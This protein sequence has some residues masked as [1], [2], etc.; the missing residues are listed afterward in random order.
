MPLVNTQG[1]IANYT[2]SLL[3]SNER[4]FT[5]MDFDCIDLSGILKKQ[6]EFIG[7]HLLLFVFI[8][9]KITLYAFRS[10]LFRSVLGGL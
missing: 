8:C 1:C 3:T 4:E 10:V 9:K 7:V 5:L 2:H 6:F